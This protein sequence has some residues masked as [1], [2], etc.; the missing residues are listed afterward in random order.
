MRK[1]LLLLHKL[2]FDAYRISRILGF[3]SA[4]KWVGYIALNLREVITT[5]TLTVADR[6]MGFGPFHVKY[7]N[8]ISFYVCGPES[9]SGIREM[10]ARDTYL[11]GGALTLGENDIVVDLG[12]NAGNFTNLAL[13]HGNNINVICVEPNKNFNA[14]WQRNLSL[15][16]GFIERATLIRAFVGEKGAKQTRLLHDNAYAGAEWLTEDALIERGN[17]SRIDFLKCDIEGGEFGLLVPGSRLLKMSSRVAAEVH[18][19]AGNVDGF[20]KMMSEQGFSLKHLQTDPDGTVT[21][22]WDRSAKSS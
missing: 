8:G 9:F 13:A 6:K 14:V 11:H 7:S 12:S 1:S 16:S 3:G 15:N 19:F 5:R 10:Y 17:I 21:G 18:S 2:F 20:L 22:L 4:T